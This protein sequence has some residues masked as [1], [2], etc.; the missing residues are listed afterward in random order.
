MK[1]LNSSRF[2]RWPAGYSAVLAVLTLLALILTGRAAPLDSLQTES[3]PPAPAYIYPGESWERIWDSAS[4]G[5][6][7]DGL[8]KVREYV[9]TL[10]T[11][12]LMVVVGGKALFEYGNLEELSYLASVRK[13]VLAVLYGKYVY[14]GTIR[15]NTTLEELKISDVDGL[16]PV[17]M[18]A[19]IDHLITAR[20]G[21]YHPASNS[22]DSTADAPPR[23]SQQPGDYFLYNN[24]D[25]NCAG[26]IFEKLT[27][28]VIYDALERDL[29]GPI[30]MQDFDRLSQRKSGNLKRSR[31]PAYHIWL[32]TRDMAR[33]GY[34]MLREGEWDGRQV[35]PRSWVRRISRVQTPVEEMNPPPYREG[36]FGYGYM[37]WVWDGPDV[38]EPYNR[39]YTAS[40]AYGQYITVLPALDMVVAHKTAVPPRKRRVRMNQYRGILE[41]LVVSRI[42]KSDRL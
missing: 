5:Y 37:W 26:Y 6:S 24:W 35:V 38:D 32:S 9:E 31:Y 20:S 41:R 2:L 19:T 28:Q 4:V 33:I 7:S 22:G 3:E 1:L 16:L 29:A 17:E 34:L 15:L 11:T 39:A 18:K 36:T 10:D 23:G 21:I 40:G 12:A 27:H 14:D 25:F 42:E 13:S 8:D 30:G